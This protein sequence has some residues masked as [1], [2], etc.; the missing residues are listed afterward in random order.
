MTSTSADL[1]LMRAALLLDSDPAAAAR[2]A[3]AILAAHP[4][5][6]EASLLLAGA[7]RR[8]GDAQAAAGILGALAAAHPRSALLQL[9]TGRALAAAG[10]GAEARAALHRAVSLDAGLADGWRELARQ[11][12]AAGDTLEGDR[13][14]ANYLRLNRPPPG[15]ADAAAALAD[16]RLAAAEAATAEFLQ[17]SPDEPFAT[18]L[19]AQ[20]ALRRLDEV[21]AERLLRRCLEQAP[22]F[23]AVR[24]ELAQ[25][26]YAQHRNAEV[27][28][29]IE[30]LLAA[31]PD[32]LEYLALKAQTL[33]L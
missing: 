33:R 22:G 13:A 19:L 17:H 26:L 18:H 28:P 24:Y 14:Y 4:G 15:L 12:F 32:N 31:D 29:L 3:G 10:R 30:R 1:E 25:L 20:I 11:L 9:E 16:N 21:E 23:A 5:H 8:L 2:E 7:C 6:T 27:Q